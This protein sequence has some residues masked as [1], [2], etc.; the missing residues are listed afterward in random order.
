[1]VAGRR[2][3]CRYSVWKRVEEDPGKI[4]SYEE[5]EDGMRVAVSSLLG[6]CLLAA[7][8]LAQSPSGPSD[9]PDRF[10]I[11]T[12]YFRLNPSTVLTYKGSSDVDFQRDLGLDSAVATFWVD[13]TWRVGRRHQ[14]KLAFTTFNQEQADHTLQRDF[15]WGGQVYSAGLSASA[16]TGADLL[17]GYYRFSI[18]RNDRFEIGPAIGFGYLWVDASIKATGT[19]TG[20]NGST[21][22]QTLDRSGSLSSPT[23][24]IGAFASGYLTKRLVA[25]GDFLYIKVT[26]GDTDSSVT[27]WRLGA[28]YYFFRNAGLAVQYKYNKYTYDRGLIATKLGGTIT[29]EGIQL[30]LTFR[31]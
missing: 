2:M 16:K 4:Q 29:Y 30:F 14:L 23:G 5:R 25:Q 31:F 3:P 12:G 11:D 27:D 7:P 10:Q 22:S 17:G 9:L 18:V 19:A 28:D 13:S 20:P 26:S 24:A 21:Q 6:A 8:A 15:T 1:M